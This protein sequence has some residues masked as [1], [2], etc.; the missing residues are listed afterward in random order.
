MQQAS[1][2][3]E[4]HVIPRMLVR[5]QGGTLKTAARSAAIVVAQELAKYAEMVHPKIS[6]NIQVIAVTCVS[7]TIISGMTVEMNTKQIVTA[8]LPPVTASQMRV[9]KTVIAGYIVVIL[10]SVVDGFRLCYPIALWGS[11]ALMAK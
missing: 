2:L 1:R 4:I 10:K 6:V 9:T 11:R 5:G 7:A 3:V 8:I